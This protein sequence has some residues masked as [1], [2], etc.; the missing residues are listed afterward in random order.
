MKSRQRSQ[1][2][3]DT[4]HFR[5]KVPSGTGGNKITL[6]ARLLY[7]KFA[8]YGTQFAFAANPTANQPASVVAPSFDD[9]KFTL[10]ASLKGVSAKQEKIPD[11]PIV[12]V[13]Q[14]QV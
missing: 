14:N 8:W 7:R 10:D 12:T 9:R 1:W 5:M 2:A 4:V 6:S 11:V 13:A 3:T